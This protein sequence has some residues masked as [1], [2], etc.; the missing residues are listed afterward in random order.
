EELA[1]PPRALDRATRYAVAVLFALVEGAD[2]DCQSHAHPDVPLGDDLRLRRQRAGGDKPSGQSTSNH[3]ERTSRCI[4][5][6]GPIAPARRFGVLRSADYLT[7][8]TVDHP[9][10]RLMSSAVEAF[11]LERCH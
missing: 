4:V 2:C 3:H 8:A 9:G 6:S 11:A 10:R 1:W 7:G 5:G